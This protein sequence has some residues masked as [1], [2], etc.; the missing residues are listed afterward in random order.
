M[1]V[2]M[3]LGYETREARYDGDL[4]IWFD[5]VDEVVMCA[6]LSTHKFAGRLQDVAHS[7]IA[8]VLL[9]VARV[10]KVIRSMDSFG[11]PL[12]LSWEALR[13]KARGGLRRFQGNVALEKP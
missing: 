1:S 13:S 8:P 9:K 4:L 6:D 11:G 5:V 7:A 12:L 10:G 2:S 3:F